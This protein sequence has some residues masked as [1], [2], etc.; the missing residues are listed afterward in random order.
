MAT[1]HAD[2]Q[3]KRCSDGPGNPKT[4]FGCERASH[5]PGRRM[6]CIEAFADGV[7]WREG[8]RVGAACLSQTLPRGTALHVTW[9]DG[10]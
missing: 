3:A 8:D 9:I 1:A 7:R 5:S 10:L 2:F 4:G 6:H